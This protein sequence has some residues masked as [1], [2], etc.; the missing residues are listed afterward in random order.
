MNYANPFI[1][2]SFCVAG[3]GLTLV[4]KIL[5]SKHFPYPSTLTFFQCI[6]TAALIQ[7][8]KKFAPGVI[9]EVEPIV[10]DKAKRWAVLVI[11]FIFMLL[12]SM[13]ALER[14]TITTLT[15]PI[16]F[17]KS[18]GSDGLFIDEMQKETRCGSNQKIGDCDIH[19]ELDKMSQLIDQA[20]FE[21]SM[22]HKG[23]NIK[24][25]NE[26]RYKTFLK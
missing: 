18:F 24:D 11:L 16:R 17:E 6:V 14:V 21:M 3:S 5:V 8:G 23:I 10:Y 9:S 7:L 2:V 19:I 20:F 15:V 22:S 25:V 4:N 26:F 12:S 13:F 1:V